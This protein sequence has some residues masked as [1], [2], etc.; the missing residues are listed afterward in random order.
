MPKALETDYNSDIHADTWDA[1]THTAEE[2]ARHAAAKGLW[3]SWAHDHA[4]GDE[5]F[6]I[7]IDART[8]EDAADTKWQAAKQGLNAELNDF[9]RQN[10][11][12]VTPMMDMQLPPVVAP[13]PA[14]SNPDQQ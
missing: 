12:E 5:V 6:G 13:Q 11:H 4:K 1:S 2:N 3:E 8:D 9:Y 10:G 14:Q 7:G